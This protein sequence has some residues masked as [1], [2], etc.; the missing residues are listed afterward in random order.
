[1]PRTRI[2]CPNCRQPIVADIDQL[3]D[4]GQDPSAKQKFLSGMFNVAQCPNCGYQ[5]LVA[6]PIVY[7]DPDKELLLTYYPAELNLPVN[8]QERMVGPLITQ[9]TNNLPQEKRKAYLFRP[10]TM[11]TLQNMI[12]TVLEADGITKEMLQAQQQKLNLIQQLASATSN[13]AMEEIAKQEDA[14]IDNEFFSILSRLIEAS[15]GGGDEASARRLGEVQQV[16]LHTTSFGKQVAEQTKEVEAAVRAL[17]AAGDKITRDQLLDLIVNAPNDLQ[18]SVM[19]SMARPGMDYDFFTKLSSRIDQ[20]TGEEKTC[21]EKLRERLLEMTKAMDQQVEAR[22]TQARQLLNG[23]L[24]AADLRQAMAQVLPAVDEFFLK[25]LEEELQVARKQ[26][27]LERSAKL[28]Q[29]N[30]LLE[31]ASAPPPE[32]A[33]I[34]EML[35]APDEESVRKLMSEHKDE[36]TPEFVELLTQLVSRPQAEN[37]EINDR[38]QMIYSQALRMS[39]QS[40][41]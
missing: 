34:Q 9:L 2:N 38:L 16:L 22:L 30:Q 13:E 36:I 35:E 6:T 14:R 26:G 15:L 21:L 12:E 4:V 5:G 41:M 20:A 3:F 23:L 24:Q 27:D 8:E 17:Q 32:F 31:E 40:N 18:L 7:H 28:S 1:M 19:V 11:L 39:M 29:I 33:L 10:Q 37:A 25:V